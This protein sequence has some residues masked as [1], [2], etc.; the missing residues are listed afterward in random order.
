MDIKHAIRRDLHFENA[1]VENRI[2]QALLKLY[3]PPLPVPEPCQIPE[4]ELVIIEHDAEA[5][6]S[7][8][9]QSAIDFLKSIIAN[10]DAQGFTS[11]ETFTR[12]SR[13]WLGKYLCGMGN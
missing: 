11:T 4:T 6:F 13:G 3:G 12:M 2:E 8:N 1:A 10:P 5:L 7:V 9:P